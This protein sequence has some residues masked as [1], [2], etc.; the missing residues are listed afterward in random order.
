MTFTN[1]DEA[2]KFYSRYAYEV[3]FPLKRY[4]ERK[5]C[6]WLNC[7]MEGKRAERGYGNPKVRNTSSKRTQCKVGMKLKKYM[8]MPKRILFQCGLILFIW[9]IIMSSLGRIQKR[10]SYSATRHMIPTTWSSLV[11]CKKAGFRNT[12]LLIFSE[13]HGGPENVPPLTTQT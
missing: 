5:N 9:N 7:S 4:R 10:I 13:M 12:V 8:M 3:G 6:K 11:R 2:Y 1:V